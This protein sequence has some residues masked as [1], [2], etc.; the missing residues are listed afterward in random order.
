MPLQGVVDMLTIYLVIVGAINLIH[1]DNGC[2]WHAPQHQVTWRALFRL[3]AS[4]RLSETI[5]QSASIFAIEVIRGWSLDIC[6]TWWRLSN[7]NYSLAIFWALLLEACQHQRRDLCFATFG[8]VLDLFA[9]KLIWCPLRVTE[10]GCP[11]A[12]SGTKNRAR[13]I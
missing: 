10:G 5:D 12:R 1:G 6:Q 3:P 2:S 8:T 7:H 4:M 11:P 9:M 13:A